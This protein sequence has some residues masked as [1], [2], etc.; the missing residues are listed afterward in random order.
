MKTK[1][2][3]LIVASI[4]LIGCASRPK[5]TISA[6]GTDMKYEWTIEIPVVRPSSRNALELANDAAELSRRYRQGNDATRSDMEGRIWPSPESIT[7][8]AWHGSITEGLWYDK[9]WN[10]DPGTVAHVFLRSG[11]GDA[12]PYWGEI[13]FMKNGKV[14]GGKATGGGSNLPDYYRAMKELGI[15]IP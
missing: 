13:V 10:Y 6:P 12:P 8:V 15:Y 7:D 3:L 11:V 2:I 1:A 14:F 4:G 9:S 5:P